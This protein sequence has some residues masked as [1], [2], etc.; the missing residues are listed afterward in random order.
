MQCSQDGEK[1]ERA[2][3][4]DLIEGKCLRRLCRSAH[5]GDEKRYGNI[6]V[7][8]HVKKM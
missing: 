8:G 3:C 2:W 5:E 1:C 4:E 6:V 7:A